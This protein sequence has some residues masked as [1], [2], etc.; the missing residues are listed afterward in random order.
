MI[1]IRVH[2]QRPDSVPEVRTPR[3]SLAQQSTFAHQ[4]SRSQTSQL[5]TRSAYRTLSNPHALAT[6]CRVS[7]CR[8]GGW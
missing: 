5:E 7:T 3:P 1:L 8:Q 2:E 4:T 6:S